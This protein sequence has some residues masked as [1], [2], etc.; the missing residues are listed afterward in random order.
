MQSIEDDEHMKD[1]AVNIILIFD[2]HMTNKS[3]NN[4]YKSEGFGIQRSKDDMSRVS[5]ESAKVF[6]Q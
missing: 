1:L 6:T 5:T 3:V 4:N 2:L